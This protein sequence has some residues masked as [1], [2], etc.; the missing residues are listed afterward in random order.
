MVPQPGH[1]KMIVFSR[2]PLKGTP[3]V[4]ISVKTN[5]ARRSRRRFRSD[6]SFSHD[7]SRRRQC[8]QTMARRRP[9]AAVRGTLRA[10]PRPR[11]AQTSKI[12]RR[13]VI[14]GRL[15]SCLGQPFDRLP[16]DPTKPGPLRW[17]AA[18]PE[19]ASGFKEA[20]VGAPG[21]GSRSSPRAGEFTEEQR[22]GEAVVPHSTA[23]TGVATE[24]PAGDGSPLGTGEHLRITNSARITAESD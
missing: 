2:P 24:G 5:P 3:A 23:Q 1:G 11:E 22:S 8:R 12:P 16:R 19:D 20:V 14:D 6:Q 7:V 9:A 21:G 17:G 13:S 18:H 10:W 4:G 15:Y